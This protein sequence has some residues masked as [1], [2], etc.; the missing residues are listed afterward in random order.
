MISALTYSRNLVYQQDRTALFYSLVLSSAGTILIWY[1]S[2]SYVRCLCRKVV[3]ILCRKILLDRRSRKSDRDNFISFFRTYL[4]HHQKVNNQALRAIL[5]RN[6]LCKFFLDRSITFQS[7]SSSF[8]QEQTLVDEFRSKL[9]LT[10]YDDYRPYIER[11]VDHGEHNLICSDKIIYYAMTSGTTGKNKLLPMTS[12]MLKDAMLLASASSSLIW[13]SLPASFP[14]CEQ[15]FFHIQSAKRRDMFA[16][17]KDNIPIGQ[18][19]QTFSAVPLNPAVQIILSAYFIIRLDLI[20]DVTDFET[21]AFVQLVLSL[22]V[23]DIYSYTVLFA[24]GFI[25]I[26][27][28]IE[29]SFEEICLCISSSDFNHSSLVCKNIPDMKLRKQLNQALNEIS[30]EYGG[31]TYRVKRAEFIR[32]QCENGNF[33]GILHRLWPKLVYAMTALGGSF[34]SYKEKIQF[35]CGKKLRLINHTTYSGSEGFFGISASIFTDEYFLSPKSNFYEFIKEEDVHLE[36]PTTYLASEIE[37]GNRYELVCTTECGLVRY[38]MGDIVSCTRFYCP[39]DDLVPLPS[40]LIDA[41]DRIPLISVAYRL[42][43]LLDIFGEKTTEQHV[44]YALQ[45]TVLQ[46]RNQDILVDLCDFTSY[47]K[48]DEFP[49]KYVIFIEVTDPQQHTD[50]RWNVIQTRADLEVERE[51]CKAN[52]IYQYIRNSG[53]L[54]PLSCVLVQ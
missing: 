11:M 10:T 19:T 47:P 17:S 37:P 3:R 24:P 41:S 1:F 23:P 21:S 32:Q 4:S 29:K 35:Y 44:M 42:G 5:E 13:R 33:E 52:N 46:W 25:H 20:E 51:L 15:R 36:Q 49:P 45:E 9:P 26:V 2:S 40:E 31:S 6:H 38:R 22:V 54:G 7:L 39:A 43:S 8:G 27:K 50:Q 34:A 14:S 53:K 30:L 12:H 18:L 16:R 28:I 48:L